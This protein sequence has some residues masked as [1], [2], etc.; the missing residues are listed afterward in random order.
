MKVNYRRFPDFWSALATAPA[1]TSVVA[2]VAIVINTSFSHQ[3]KMVQKELSYDLETVH[4]LFR[5]QK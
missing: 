5:K 3:P 4:E 1:E 2:M